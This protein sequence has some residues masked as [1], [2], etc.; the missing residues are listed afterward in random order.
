MRAY[1][2][3]A[4]VVLISAGAFTHFT[5]GT[6]S[7]FGFE[8]FSAICPL[9]FLET[10]LASGTLVPR[11]LIGLGITLFATVL[12]GRVFC[13]WGCPIPYVRLWFSS[14]NRLNQGEGLSAGAPSH[15]VSFSAAPSP[16]KVEHETPAMKDTPGT[17]YFV[18]GGA[19]LSSAIFGFPVFCL[20]C[21]IGLFFGTLFA[22]ARLLRFNEPTFLL[23]V[24]PAVLVIEVV[25]LRSWCRKICPVGALIELVSALNRTLRPHIDRSACLAESQGI[26]CLACKR[27][28]PEGIDL[29]EKHTGIANGLCTK[30][31]DCI[32]V[33]PAKA[34]SFFGRKKNNVD[35]NQ[36]SSQF[37]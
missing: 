35:S 30:C 8:S 3:S 29:H 26:S 36:R 9:G 22:L 12:L 18:L 6:L 24:F 19:L 33:C 27:V 25:F 16:R 23:L 15:G 20:I 14:K 28:C 1:C 31:G 17:K 10:A 2:V 21:P 11:A 4:I 7:S 37:A 34:I 13:A 5:W 32:D